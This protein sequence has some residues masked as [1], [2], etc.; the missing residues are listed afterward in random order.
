MGQ[1]HAAGIRRVLL[2]QEFIRI[3][4][5]GKD[6]LPKVSD[7]GGGHVLQGKYR[8]SMGKQDRRHNTRHLSRDIWYTTPARL[9]D[10]VL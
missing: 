1:L 9:P 3:D 6:T 4:L 2:K 7:P 10:T 8:K 5:K